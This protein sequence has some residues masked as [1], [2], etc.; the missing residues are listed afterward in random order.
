MSNPNYVWTVL[1]DEFNG[2]Q[3]SNLW[4]VSVGCKKDKY[5]TFLYKFVNDG[6]TVNVSNGNLNLSLIQSQSA[7]N[8]NDSAVYIKAGEVESV[9]RYKYGIYECSATFSYKKGA[10]PAFWTISA[11]PC[12]QFPVNEMDIVE[13]KYEDNNVTYDNNLFYYPYPCGN[14]N[15]PPGIQS[16][17]F[18]WSTTHTY[19]LIWSIEKLEFY[20]DNIKKREI[21]NSG[22]Y[23]YPIYDQIV[24]LS[25]QATMYNK[26]SPLY[27]VELPSTSAF[28]WVKVREFFLAPEITSSAS[29]ICNNSTQV[30]LDV[31]L[32]ATNFQWNVQPSGYFTSATSGY[33]KTANLTRNS[34]ANGLA[35]ITYTFSMPSGEY[36]TANHS[37]W[38]GQNN[39]LKVTYEDGSPVPTN[40]YGEPVACPNTNY[41]FSVYSNMQPC[42]AGNTTWDV[43]NEW[44]IN[45]TNGNEISINTNGSP[46]NCM[47]AD[48]VDCCGN[49]ITMS[50][51]LENSSSCGYYYMSINPNPTIG[52]TAIDILSKDAKIPVD[53]NVEWEFSIYDQSMSLKEKAAKIKGKQAKFNTQDWKEGVYFIKAQY[54]NE[55]LSEK[56]VVK[57]Q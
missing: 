28:H 47:Y 23:W 26:N 48:A 10:F 36:F 13:M 54:K 16:T 20:A 9:G 12:N 29:L 11:G 17:E 41:K 18:N 3:L 46:Y 35:T 40:N 55:I 22:Q 37:F 15:S 7:I 2:N 33:G 32:R 44:S 25:Q 56:L 43:P 34:S 5:K 1:Y 4:S 24:L 53:E 49:Y 14:Q 39:D 8:C 31:D 52:E 19:K 45:Y 38:V 21:I 57:K 51:C 27:G 30:V 6:S 42:Y 50:L